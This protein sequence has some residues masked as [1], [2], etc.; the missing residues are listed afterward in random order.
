MALKDVVEQSFGTLRQ[1]WIDCCMECKIVV[2]SA[3]HEHLA[4]S[5]ITPLTGNPEKRSGVAAYSSCCYRTASDT[6][7]QHTNAQQF[8]SSFIIIA[9]AWLRYDNR[10]LIVNQ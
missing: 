9:K 4:L 10:L 5:L 6:T 2:L 3:I 8:P 1:D 7:D